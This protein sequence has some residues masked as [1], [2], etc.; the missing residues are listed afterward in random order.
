MPAVLGS[1]LCH[2]FPL[3]LLTALRITAFNLDV[4]NTLTKDGEKGSLFGFSVALH[5]Q[6]SSEPMS[7]LLVGA[8][9]AS[10]LP[11]QHANRTGALYGCPLTTKP[12]DCM[13]VGIDHGVDVSRESKENQWLGVTVKSQG[14]GGKIVTCAH[15]YETRQRVT[16]L[17]ETRDVIGRCFVLSDNLKINDDLD[18]EEWKFC[19]GRALGH[20]RF[21]FCQQGVSAGFTNDNHYIMF[22]APGTYNWKGELRVEL[23]N[24]SALALG[25]YDDGPYEVAGE[26]SQKPEMIPVPHHSYFG[27]RSWPDAEEKGKG[28]KH[29]VEPYT[30]LYTNSAFGGLLGIKE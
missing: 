2:W 20:E 1:Q 16:Q 21:G 18:G 8:P 4:T 12:K 23:F 13:R 30:A 11:S 24:Q 15:L 14:P 10:A 22:G 9:Q 25:T 5:K 29:R 6:L 26:K 28:E 27:M 17:S 7:W 19:E 3:L